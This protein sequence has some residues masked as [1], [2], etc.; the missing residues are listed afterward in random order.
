MKKLTLAALALCLSASLGLFAAKAPGGPKVLFHS[1]T[2]QGKPKLKADQYPAN[3]HNVDGKAVA[4]PKKGAFSWEYKVKGKKYYVIVG[5]A[6]KNKQAAT[7]AALH[8]I[9]Q[10]KKGNPRVGKVPLEIKV[11]CGV[12]KKQVAKELPNGKVIG[13]ELTGS[14]S[15]KRCYIVATGEVN[16]EDAMQVYFALAGLG[17]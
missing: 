8:L 10:A 1:I 9:P 2:V 11:V 12:S 3:F 13:G 16:D 6:D 5:Y 14:P 15:T 17:L 7:D 4:K